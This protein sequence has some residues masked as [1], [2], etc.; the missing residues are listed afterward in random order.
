MLIVGDSL[1]ASAVAQVRRDACAF[2]QD[3]YRG[4][5]GTD[6][7]QFMH[8]VVGHA[9]E[10]RIERDVIIDVHPGPAPL[11]Q[12]EWFRRERLQ[13]R[14]VDRLPD[15]RPRSILLTERPMIQLVQ[16]LADGPI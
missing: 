6:L 1:P 3:L 10:V 9:V 14:F 4:G 7:D 2:V 15:R 11:A 5:R 12:V 16:Q 13:G 8:Q